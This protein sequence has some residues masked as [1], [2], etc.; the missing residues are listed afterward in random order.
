M[1]KFLNN[2]AAI[3]LCSIPVALIPFLAIFCFIDITATDSMMGELIH[4]LDYLASLSSPKIVFIG[5]SGCSHGIDSE[6]V[7]KSFGLPVANMGLH[8]GMGLAYQLSSIDEYIHKGDYVVIIP[9]YNNFHSCLGER[10]LLMVISDILPLD[11][12]KLDRAQWCNLLQ[13]MPEYGINKIKRLIKNGVKYCFK[14]HVIKIDK[15]YGLYKYDDRG[16]MIGSRD[17]NRNLGFKPAGF[18]SAAGVLIGNKNDCIRRINRFIEAHRDAT[19]VVFP[20]AFQDASFD[21]QIEY[22]NAVEKILEKNG[23]PYVARPSRYR[24]LNEECWDTPYHLNGRGIQ[25]RTKQLIEDLRPLILT[26]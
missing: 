10:E 14:K 12:K 21:N 20:A 16:D 2:I 6:I 17:D 11:R 19:V 1:K 3:G 4:K 9:E 24:M 18:Q 25:R 5:G 23:T 22:I 26:K 13:Y 7:E 15:D 8:A